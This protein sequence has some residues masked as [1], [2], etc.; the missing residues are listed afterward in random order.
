MIRVEKWQW[1]LALS[2]LI[3]SHVWANTA[4]P[5]S[6]PIGKTQFE[7][8][9][10]KG[11]VTRPVNV[12]MFVPER[13]DANCP[14]QFVMHG[15]QR[16]AETYLD[17]WVPLAQSAKEKFIIV[18]PEFTRKYFPQD[19]D[20]SLGRTKVESDS[21][22]WAFAVPEHLFDELK[23]RFG[24]KAMTYRLF[25]HS[26]G[27]QFVHRLHMFYPQHR[28][29]PI[30]AANP[31]WYTMFEWGEMGKTATKS[32]AFPYSTKGSKINDM[33]ARQA[34][35]RPFILML[36]DADI[37]PHDQSLNRSA[38]ANA[39]GEFRFARG[40]QFFENAKDAAKQLG[41][42]FAWKQVIVPAVAHDGKRMS[43]AAFQLMVDR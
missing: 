8:V 23:T 5:I 29:N 35:S 24:L 14:I 12:W 2:I 4:A 11:D 42:Q 31:G 32:F 18:A 20:Y 41:V 22:K 30:I 37:D 1:L 13:C 19:D 36:G 7:F 16:N 40:K 15:V 26:A 10:K 21:E 17:Y 34:L 3:Y 6:L 25:G 33:R 28:A 38:G 43:Q 9:D 39:Q 27:G